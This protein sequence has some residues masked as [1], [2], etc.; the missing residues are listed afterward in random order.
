MNKHE[1]KQKKIQEK[2]K[3]LEKVNDEDFTTNHTFVPVRSNYV[4]SQ[5]EKEFVKKISEFNETIVK[6]KFYLNLEKD[7]KL[8]YKNQFEVKNYS[9]YN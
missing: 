1:Q 8:S 3:I 5:E 7:E 2:K 4:Q 9:M 6:S